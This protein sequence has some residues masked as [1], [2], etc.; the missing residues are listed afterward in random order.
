MQ[1][2]ILNKKTNSGL[3]WQGTEKIGSYGIRFVVSV[4]LARLLSPEEFGII[5]IMIVILSLC[6]IFIDSGFGVALVQKKDIDEKDCNSV[7][8]INICFAFIT[9]VLILLLSPYIASYY[10]IPK[11]STYISVFALVIVIQSFSI[12]QVAL[13]RKKMMF[14]VCF[15]VNWLAISLSGATGII[16]AYC[17]Y[18]VWAL[19]VQQII[20]YFVMALM[21]WFLVKWRPKLTFDIRRIFYLF[22]FGWKILCAE[23][24]NKLYYDVYALV[25]GKIADLTTLSYYDRGKTFPKYGMDIVNTT[26]SSVLLPAFSTVQNDKKQMYSLAQMIL[27]TVMF[28]VIPILTILFTFA[29]EI[30]ITVLTEKWLPCVP[31]MRL[32]CIAFVFW[33]LHTVNLYSIMATGRSNVYLTLEVIRKLQAILFILITFHYGV[34]A[35]VAGSVVAELISAI[36]NAWYCGKQIKYYIWIQARDIAPFFI[37]SILAAVISY[38]GSRLVNQTILCILCGASLYCL[39]YF[40]LCIIF[41]IAPSSIFEILNGLLKKKM[42]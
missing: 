25:I 12:I 37:M 19:I 41:K 26:M 30:T 3:I 11:I 21:Y 27:K 15:K 8:Y 29:D 13:L 24:L 33:P 23:I 6:S 31:F 10:E 4:I 5:A 14:N 16:L 17:G 42:E 2:D 1:T 20:N 9:Y 18:G 40:T 39:I 7:F 38:Y 32:C 22:N 36:V 28:I 34:M 35:I